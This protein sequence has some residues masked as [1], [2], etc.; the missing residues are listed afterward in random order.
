MLPPRWS[1]PRLSSPAMSSSSSPNAAAASHAQDNTHD[2]PVALARLLDVSTAII[3]QAVDLVDN[4]LTSDEQ[5]TAHSN[6][7]PGS[8]IGAPANLLRLP[9]W[10]FD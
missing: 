10:R 6:Y 1:F 3:R 4:C 7:I 9:H 2:E 5:L 8:T